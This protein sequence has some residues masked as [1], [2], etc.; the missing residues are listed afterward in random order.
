MSER[1]SS[2]LPT[3]EPPTHADGLCAK[4]NKPLVPVGQARKGGKRMPTGPNKYHKQ[5]C[6]ARE[7]G[8][9]D[10]EPTPKRPRPPPRPRRSP[11]YDARAELQVR[12]EAAH[13]RRGEESGREFYTCGAGRS[14]CRVVPDAERAGGGRCAAAARAGQPRRPLRRRRVVVVSPSSSS[15]GGGG[16]GVHRRLLNAA[17]TG[18]AAATAVRR[19][20]ARRRRR[21]RRGRHGRRRVRATPLR[22]AAFGHAVP[23]RSCS[24]R[25]RRRRCATPTA[26]DRAELARIGATAG[27]MTVHGHG[28]AEVIR[29]L[30]AAAPAAAAPGGRTCTGTGT[31][32]APASASDGGHGGGGRSSPREQPELNECAC[33]LDGVNDRGRLLVAVTSAFGDE[34]GF[35]SSRRSSCATSKRVFMSVQVQFYM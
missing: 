21:R 33:A 15:G 27:R 31:P 11:P 5:C 4:C 13:K 28:H 19:A 29:A 8:L 6:A 10:D 16:G 35:S 2:S 18:D 20:R 14:S 23:S 30:E 24:R 1:A 22:Y 12:R 25:A 9:D 7:R 34:S 26:A 3:M 17:L 32:P